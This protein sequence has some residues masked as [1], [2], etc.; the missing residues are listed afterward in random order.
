MNRRLI[1]TLLALALA[2]PLHW[3][4]NTPSGGIPEPW[5]MPRWRWELGS[6]FTG[7]FTVVPGLAVGFVAGR[8]GLLLGAVVGYLGH[9]LGTPWSAILDPQQ[10]NVPAA[11]LS[12]LLAP[13]GH[14]I[15]SAAGGGAGQLLR[16]NTSLER[17]RER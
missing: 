6:L 9:M 11:L 2:I 15:I 1:I 8:H 17:T 5:H 4:L 3:Y 13:L 14:A 7:L 16:S 10:S 12:A